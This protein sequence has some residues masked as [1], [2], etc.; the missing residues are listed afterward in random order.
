MAEAI[1]VFA[2]DNNALVEQKEFTN[3][4]RA[5]ISTPDG[6]VALKSSKDEDNTCWLENFNGFNNRASTIADTGVIKL[7]G[8][9]YV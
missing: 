3:F 9:S 2:R 4:D 7:Q 1:V 8:Y 6:C 5:I